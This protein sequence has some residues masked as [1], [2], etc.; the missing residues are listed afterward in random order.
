MANVLGASVTNAHDQVTRRVRK[1]YLKRESQEARS[2]TIVRELADQILDLGPVSIVGRVATGQPVLAQENIAVGIIF[3][4]RHSGFD[5]G[6][7]KRY[8]LW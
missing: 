3:I 7:D 4:T 2:L 8:F 5:D 6:I 1:G